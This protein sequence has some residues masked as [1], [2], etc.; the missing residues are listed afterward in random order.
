MTFQ[1]GSSHISPVS[2]DDQKNPKLANW[3][4][5]QRQERKLL[6]QG[7]A[8]RLIPEQ[9]RALE[10]IGF[11]WE[12]Q[13]GGPRKKRGAPNPPRCSQ[14][15]VTAPVAPVFPGNSL[16][17]GLP[18]ATSG[19]SHPTLTGATSLAAAELLQGPAQDPVAS[20]GGAEAV[21]MHRI[22]MMRNR[23]EAAAL[24]LA[25]EQARTSLEALERER[26]LQYERELMIS[27]ALHSMGHPIS[28]VHRQPTRGP[29][30]FAQG[31][32]SSRALQLASLSSPLEPLQRSVSGFPQHR[33][34][35][36]A[37]L[38][39]EVH[40]EQGRTHEVPSSPLQGRAPEDTDDDGFVLGKSYLQQNKR[41]RLG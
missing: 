13:R 8:S 36:A 22:E 7:R 37:Q 35:G 32:L 14:P 12:A 24:Y 1:A 21:M 31:M 40:L 2:F 26:T 28:M 5:T 41:R 30:S 10:Q 38:M 23:R 9:V 25:R 29:I 15:M 34:T 4:S 16:Q 20:L 6:V 3:V 19:L 33:G 17:A 39:Q 18:L 27:N 11:V